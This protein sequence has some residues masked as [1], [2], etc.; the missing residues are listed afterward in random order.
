MRVTLVVVSATADGYIKAGE[1]DYAFRLRRFCVLQRE[2]VRP[3]KEWGRL[4]GEVQR[5][6]ESTLLL[7]VL[8][9]KRNVWL[10]DEGGLEMTSVEFS[11]LLR[12][13]GVYGGGEITFA[14]GGAY[15][16]GEAV[17]AKYGAQKLSLSRMTFTHQMVRLLFLEQLYRGF[18][19]QRGGHY[20]HA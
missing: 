6:R 7:P 20:H 18:M 16:F 8:E 3:R 5:E 17:R 15:G 2:E 4:D 14:I 13:V 12:H 11:A 19:I 1:E 10:L 9:G